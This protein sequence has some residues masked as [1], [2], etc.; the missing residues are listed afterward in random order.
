MG[1]YRGVTVLRSS[2]EPAIYGSAFVNICINYINVQLQRPAT[3]SLQNFLQKVGRY[4]TN[5]L[6]A[7]LPCLNDAMFR[8]WPMAWSVLDRVSRC[9]CLIKYLCITNHC[10]PSK[11]VGRGF[12]VLWPFH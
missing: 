10:T 8:R 3:N 1:G 6:V 12:P 2:Y 9:G 7:K 4:I 5:N 11:V